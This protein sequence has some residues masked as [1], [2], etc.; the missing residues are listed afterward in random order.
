MIAAEVR[1][2]PELPL[3]R[4]ALG[5]LVL[6]AGAALPQPLRALLTLP[7][8]LLVPGYAT[9]LVLRLSARG[10][11]AATTLVTSLVVSMAVIPLAAMALD[12]AGHPAGGAWIL[13]AVAAYSLVA[14]LAS[15]RLGTAAAPLDRRLLRGLGAL[16]VLAALT[17]AVIAAGV[18]LLPG[19]PPERYTMVG[20]AGRLATVDG[21]VRTAAGR[22]LRVPLTITNRTG[23]P[24]VYTIAPRMRGGSW[25]HRR[26]RVADG[27]TWRGG[28]SGTVP[29][30]GCLHRLL[31]AVDGGG[32]DIDGPIVWVQT[33]RTLPADC[34][35]PS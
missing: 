11:D 21:P 28:V 27:A 2:L 33:G 7:A 23:R 30:G 13:G 32:V 35:R 15:P 16:A 25:Q 17:A 22:P 12:L 9:L 34:R 5:A 6:V 19:E 14:A 29:A 31:V 24:V 26:V 18:R 20:L 4:V 10:T 3:A 1:R 8:L